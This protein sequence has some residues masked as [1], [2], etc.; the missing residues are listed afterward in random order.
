MLN[1]TDLRKTGT[2]LNYFYLLDRLFV[3]KS[4]HIRRLDVSTSTPDTKFLNMSLMEG[5]GS[6]GI[7]RPFQLTQKT[8][9][10]FANFLQANKGL[11]GFFREESKGEKK[12]RK[13]KENGEN[14]P[15]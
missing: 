6:I 11:I 1:S 4:P 9:F 2:V 3:D 8:T 5:N 10:C 13:S 14:G 12:W 15:K 7:P